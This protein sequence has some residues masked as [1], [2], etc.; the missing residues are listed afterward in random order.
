MNIFALDTN[1]VVAAQQQCNKHTVKMVLESAQMLSTAHRILDGKLQKKPSKSGKT[2]VSHWVL[3][4]ER[5]DILYKAV[6]VNHP[7]T[8]WTYETSGNYLWHYEHFVALCDEYTYRYGKT[9]LSDTLL[10]NRLSQPPNNI[11]DLPRTPFAVAMGSNPECIIDDDPVLSYRNYY[12]TKQD[13]FPMVWTKRQI[14]EW[15]SLNK[16]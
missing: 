5:D 4:D 15:F 1:P 3:P 8:I 10:R 9:H 14:P 7:C 6:H 13:R 2:L 11:P 16:I 12:Q